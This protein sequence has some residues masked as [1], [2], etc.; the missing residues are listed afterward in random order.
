MPAN[1]YTFQNNIQYTGAPILLNL[2][3][4]TGLILSIPII[5]VQIDF[6]PNIL[7]IVR[8]NTHEI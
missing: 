2:A 7:A 8:V 6:R 4:P 5:A 3:L 1:S